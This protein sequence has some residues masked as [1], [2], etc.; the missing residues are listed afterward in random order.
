MNYI[1]ENV[2]KNCKFTKKLIC[3]YVLNNF[4][5]TFHSTNRDKS[6]YSEFRNTRNN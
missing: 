3:F 5:R 2:R 6:Y 1:F 4:E